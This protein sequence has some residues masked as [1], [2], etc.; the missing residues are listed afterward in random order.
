MTTALTL[1]HGKPS[2]LIWAAWDAAGGEK[3]LTREVMVVVKTY[4][5]KLAQ[6]IRAAK[7]H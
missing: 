1:H 5:G 7:G 2:R 3:K 6:Q 4:E